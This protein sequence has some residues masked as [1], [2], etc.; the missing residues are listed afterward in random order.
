[1]NIVKVWEIL[2]PTTMPRCSAKGDVEDYANTHP[3]SVRHHHQWDGFVRKRAGGLTI[4][5][6]TKGQW[7]CPKTEQVFDERMIPVRIACTKPQILEIARFTI[8][9]YRQKAVMYYKVSDEVEI[10]EK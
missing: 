9:H 6:P 5:R 7:V 4:M 1:M 10:L 3:V 8:S 2:V